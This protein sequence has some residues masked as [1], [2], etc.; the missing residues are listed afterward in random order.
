MGIP[1]Q[2]SD[3]TTRARSGLDELAGS[4]RQAEA[5]LQ[6]STA[7]LGRLRDA[8]VLGVIVQD[9]SRV[10]EANDAYLDIIGYSRGDL[11][12]G[13]IA[14]R[15]ITPP[16][17][18]DAQDNAIAQLRQSGAYP[19]FEKEYVRKDGRRVPV[20]IGAAVIGRDP[21]RWTSFVIDLSAWRRAER[22]R[23]TIAAKARA[24]RAG[25]RSARERLDFLMR[26]GALVAA[27]RDRDEL[28]DQVAGLAVPSL[29]DFCVV[30]LSTG[31][32][33]LV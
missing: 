23:A 3:A 20:L 16:E 27:T 19:P 10:C 4:L 14:W 9:E 11:E 18:A 21:L 25:A 2:G 1:R 17:W 24:D 32:E 33:K 15:E 12:A 5:A 13:R 6:Q 28:L 29:A 30:Y 8:N 26:A 7:L 31:D 22:D